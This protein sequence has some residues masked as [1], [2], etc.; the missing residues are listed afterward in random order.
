VIAA[1]A[2]EPI[3]LRVR[4][5]ERRLA[6]AVFAS[7][8]SPRVRELTRVAKVDPPIVASWMLACK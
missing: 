5:E 7:S 8:E 1:A 2:P 3:P 4:A 6:A